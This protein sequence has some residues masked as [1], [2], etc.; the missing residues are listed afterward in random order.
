MSASTAPRPVETFAQI[1]G[2][3]HRTVRDL[4]FALVDAFEAGELESARALLRSLAEA[5]GPH[6]RYEEESLYPEL[7]PIF[8]AGYVDK[9]LRDHDWAIEHVRRLDALA[10]KDRL[11]DDETAEAVRL[12][13]AILPHV[14]DCDGL[15]LM[16]EL[17]PDVKVGSMLE[18]REAALAD[19]LDLLAW[20]STKRVR[21]FGDARR[22]DQN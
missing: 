12:V 20:A 15:T 13:R 4:L 7:V 8:G 2:A 5:T 18:T 9:L 3:E 1:F 6:F 22:A 19:G 17:L 21:G 16:V 11:T 10:A 14:S